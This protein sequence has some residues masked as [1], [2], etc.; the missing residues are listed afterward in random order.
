MTATTSKLATLSDP[1]SDAFPAVDPGLVPFGERVL[2]QIRTPKRKSA[3][4]IILHHDTRETELWNTQVGKIIS[5]GPGAFK[6]RDTLEPW[7]EGEW[8]QPGV[9]VRVPKYGGDRWEVPIPGTDEKAL[10]VIF[11]DHNLI[12]QITG[13]PLAVIAFI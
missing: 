12:G 4:G 11:K 10:F 5:V 1:L 13:D 2:V 7:P 3:G 6:N 8:A 9:F